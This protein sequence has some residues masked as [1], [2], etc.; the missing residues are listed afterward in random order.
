MAKADAFCKGVLEELISR[1]IISDQQQQQMEDTCNTAA[2]QQP[3]ISA[4]SRSVSTTA[5]ISNTSSS[6][7]SRQSGEK[8][9]AAG[10]CDQIGRNAGSVAASAGGG[11]GGGKGRKAAS[12]KAK[13][14]LRPPHSTPIITCA[15]I[16]QVGK[17]HPAQPGFAPSSMLA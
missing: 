17:W 1:G 16:E 14:S 9:S 7:D 6:I 2:S 11:G 4:S 10:D 8:D 13:G 3:R 15:A 12:S 5:V